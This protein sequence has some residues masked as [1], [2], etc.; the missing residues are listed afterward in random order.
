MP[1]DSDI[2]IKLAY[3]K[4]IE[5]KI[6]TEDETLSLNVAYDIK[7]ISNNEKYEPNEFD[8]NVK[9]TISGI[10]DKENTAGL[11]V[12]HIDDEDKIEEIKSISIEEENLSF[13][14]ETFSIFAIVSPSV[15]YTQ[16]NTAWNGSIAN[17]FSWGTGT[18]NDPYLIATGEEL[19]YLR[20][21]VNN[22]Y[23]YSRTILQI[24]R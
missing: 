20:T 8:E 13:N 1:K 14:T 21:Q 2:N 24:N 23:T 5:D 22:G 7:I 3:F 11:K 9:V 4:E 17:K 19:A 18:Q 12:I 15:N 10:V 16:A 6:K